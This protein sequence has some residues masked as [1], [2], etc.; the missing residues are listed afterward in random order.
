VK[1]WF[2]P[3]E[4]AGLPGLPNT[5]RGINK[6]LKTVAWESRPRAGRGGGREYSI[7]ALPEITRR[8][9]FAQEAQSRGDLAPKINE[10]KALTLIEPQAI[11][12]LKDWQREVMHARLAVLAWVDQIATEY[13]SKH[14]AI[15]KSLALIEQG[16]LP[17]D[18]A[19]QIRVAN[20][21]ASGS[22]RLSNSTLYDW[23]KIRD[24]IGPAGLAPASGNQTAAP[25]WFPMLLKLY[26]CPQKPT[27]AKC[28]RDFTKVYPDHPIPAE[29]TA[30]RW[31]QKLPVEMRE[32]GRMGR[33]ARRAVQPFTRRTTDGMWPMDIVT[34][35]G[36]LF[37][38]YVRHPMT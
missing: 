34:V 21:R 31:L 12:D 2:S 11:S 29:R 30:N 33:A 20:A 23:F 3:A 25:M 32:F 37:K 28:L 36:H 19:A 16:H 26:Q 15:I 17:E 1:S 27:L 35:D 9:L 4:L 13:R 38:A 6:L 7:D 18:I 24:S 22:S 10:S 5:K 14:K 8:Y